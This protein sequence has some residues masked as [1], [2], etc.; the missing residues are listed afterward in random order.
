MIRLPLV[1]KVFSFDNPVFWMIFALSSVSH[2]NK[3]SAEFFSNILLFEIA[4]QLKGETLLDQSFNS[5]GYL[6]LFQIFMRI[7]VPRNQDYLIEISIYYWK[8]RNW[9]KV[10][11]A[12]W[13]KKFFEY[14]SLLKEM[15]IIQKFSKKT[16][17]RNLKFCV[18]PRK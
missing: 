9:P 15:L 7:S 11:K 8:G 10:F 16:E 13:E 18:V 5:Y 4:Y 6:M 12:V 17:R 1:L 3:K 2:N 14:N